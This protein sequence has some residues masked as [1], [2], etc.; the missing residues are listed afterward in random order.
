MSVNW[1]RIEFYKGNSGR[2]AI[3]LTTW[4]L[5]QSP[6]G[7]SGGKGPNCFDFS[8]SLRQLKSLQEH[9]KTYIHALRSYTSS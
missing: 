7:L 8:M 5:G 6:G 4:G 3:V 1:K 2:K 9:Q